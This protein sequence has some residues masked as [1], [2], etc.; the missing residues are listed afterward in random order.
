MTIQKINPDTIAPPHGHAQVIVATGG[1][2]VFTSKVTMSTNE[3][4]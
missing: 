1:K 3:E 4:R 2:L